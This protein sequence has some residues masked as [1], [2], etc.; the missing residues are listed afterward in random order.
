MI[1]ELEH[2]LPVSLQWTD[3]SLKDVVPSDLEVEQVSD[4]K[5]EGWYSSLWSWLPS[6]IGTWKL[7]GLEALLPSLTAA[8]QQYP[9]KVRKWGKAAKLEWGERKLKRI[10]QPQP[11]PFFKLAPAALSWVLSDARGRCAQSLRLYGC[12]HRLPWGSATRNLLYTSVSGQTSFFLCWYRFRKHGRNLGWDLVTSSL[13][14]SFLLTTSRDVTRLL[15][16]LVVPKEPSVA[17]IE[18]KGTGLWDQE[19]KWWDL[20][21]R[22]RQR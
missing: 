9:P 4:M 13:I 5:V 10:D 17:R 22:L 15:R 8:T 20:R 18:P 3:S 11:K 16:G 21:G 19:L 6:G 1:D 12:S 7:D 2:W 14:F